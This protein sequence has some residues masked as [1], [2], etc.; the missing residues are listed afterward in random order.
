MGA[1]FGDLLTVADAHWAEATE[2]LE[3][4]E[5]SWQAEDQS[6]IDELSQAALVLARYAERAG[7]GFGIQERETATAR[8]AR[9]CAASLRDAASSLQGSGENAPERCE[10]ARS[11]F[12]ARQALGCGLD[13]LS[14][15]FEVDAGRLLPVTT[16][17]DLISSAS[18]A[19]WLLTAVDG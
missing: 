8:R 4:P 15:H 9:L 18:S 10:L 7:T 2:W 13:L 16:Q 3:P 12:M 5:L 6:T 17:S 1:T 11:L 14:A 19:E